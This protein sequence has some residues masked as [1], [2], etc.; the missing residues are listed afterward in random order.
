MGSTE[1]HLR[2]CRGSHAPA[3][4]PALPC[5]FAAG[6]SMGTFPAWGDFGNRSARGLC[7][8]TQHP[9]SVPLC[10]P[11][12]SLRLPLHPSCIPLLPPAS[13]L[14]ILLPSPASRLPPPSSL[15]H[16]PASPASPCLP[17]H[18]SCIPPASPCLLLPF[19][20][21]RLHPSFLPL[22]FPTSLSLPCIPPPPAR[23]LILAAHTEADS[24]RD[25]SWA[26]FK[27]S[28]GHGW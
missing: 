19:P 7:P 8:N 2:G 24:F 6:R 17:L 14:P 22:P 21:S 25:T 16:P 9:R 27:G 4:L 15:L 28:L 13:R 3:G 23:G 1:D 10:L 18:P 5:G 20:P 12:H 11:L 26:A